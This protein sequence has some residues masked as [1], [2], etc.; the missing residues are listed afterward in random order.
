M[1][2]GLEAEVF[3]YGVSTGLTLFVAEGHLHSSR[4]MV[5]SIQLASMTT[6][7][8]RV[9]S[10]PAGILNTVSLAWC[11]QFQPRKQHIV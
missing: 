5:A 4:D 11:Q 2:T 8:R 6:N 3:V 9:E 10:V 7:L 1:Q